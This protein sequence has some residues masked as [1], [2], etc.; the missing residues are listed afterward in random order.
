V[1]VKIAGFNEEQ[2]NAVLRERAPQFERSRGDWNQEIATIMMGS[3]H[4]VISAFGPLAFPNQQNEIASLTKDLEHLSKDLNA[5]SHHRPGYAAT[6]PSGPK[7][8]GLIDSMLKTS[9]SVLGECPWHLDAAIICGDQPKV[10]TGEAWSHSSPVRR[11]LRV[12]AW[13]GAPIPKHALLWNKTRMNPIIT[14]PVFIQRPGAPG[15]RP[16][17][18]ALQGRETP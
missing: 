8:A 16:L 9:A 15:E 10:I 2:I 13:T 7:I 17:R 1:L 11:L 3:E 6:A 18:R 4:L 14:D 12:I 5:L